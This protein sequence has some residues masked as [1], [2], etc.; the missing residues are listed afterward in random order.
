MGRRGWRGAAGATSFRVL[1]SCFAQAASIA[2]GAKQAESTLKKSAETPA[3]PPSA[4][5][6]PSPTREFISGEQF[7]SP[8]APSS[9]K[10]SCEASD[11]SSR[12][13]A[14]EDQLLTVAA[15]RRLVEQRIG[16]R[17]PRS[18]FYRW[19][20]DGTLLSVRIMHTV[21]IPTSAVAKFLTLRCEE[22]DRDP[23]QGMTPSDREQAEQH[24]RAIF[25]TLSAEVS[26][27]I[28]P[29]REP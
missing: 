1:P 11:Q 27:P 26:Q 9:P 6:A 20:T 25:E 7:T 13:T 19:V 8:S 4:S 21:R 17:V 24:N 12:A 16:I 28:A 10:K 15:A 23:F 5:A 2:A 3:R 14:P 29:D 22:P 18:T